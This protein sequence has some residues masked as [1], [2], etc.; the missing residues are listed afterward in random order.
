LRKVAIVS[1]GYVGFTSSD[2]TL[3]FQEEMFEAAVKAYSQVG[4]NPRSDIDSFVSASEDYWEGYSIFDEFIPDQLGGVLKPVCTVAQD[5]VNAVIN[6]AMQIMA[7]I[8]DVAVAEAHSKASNL[9]SRDHIVAFALDPVFNRPL[10][11]RED[12]RVLNPVLIAGLEMNHYMQD[13]DVTL[14][15]IAQVVVKNRRNALKTS[16]AAYPADL[17]VEQVLESEDIAYPL[18]KL[19]IA[20]PADGAIVAVLAAEEEARKLTD[21]PV[22][23]K[24]MG[25][26]SGTPIIEERDLTLPLAVRKAADM[27][28]KMAEIEAPRRQLDLVLVDDQYA[29]KELQH[30]EA[31][32]LAS[33]GEAAEMLEQGDLSLSGELPVN[34]EGG[35][36]G[37]G[38][39]LEASGLQKV[40]EAYLQ[41]TGQAARRQI[42]GAETA[43]VQ[44]WRGIPTETT[45][46]LI[47]S[48]S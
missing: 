7:G 9:L 29:Y 47:L 37:V 26:C 35:Q 39:L 43:L 27:A 23:I 10:L 25:W 40:L 24:G 20:Q 11:K 5:G 33:L 15:Q 21:S 4:L 16:Y 45:S 1:I 42:E 6:A 41:L 3:S 31:M 44:A 32:K 36:L 13:A 8:A 46:V 2:S 38:H 19:M 30:I 17:T 28:Y 22:W 14:E 12:G 34:P 18:K 48:R